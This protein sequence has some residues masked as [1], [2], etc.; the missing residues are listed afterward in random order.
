MGSCQGGVHKV[1]SGSDRNRTG[2]P[3]RSKPERMD[4]KASDMRGGYA[5]P[6]L[7]RTLSD[8]SRETIAQLALLEEELTSHEANINQLWSEVKDAALDRQ[9]E[10]VSVLAQLNGIVAEFECKKVDSLLLSHLESGQREAREKRRALTARCQKLFDDLET[11]WKEARA[12]V[13]EKVR[14]RRMPSEKTESIKKMADL[15]LGWADP[16]L[17]QQLRSEY[18]PTGGTPDTALSAGGHHPGR[19]EMP[20]SR[21]R[22]SK[23]EKAIEEGDEDEAARL[24]QLYAKTK[25]SEIKAAREAAAR[26]QMY[27]K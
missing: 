1:Q 19:P 2:N 9:K 16:S 17:A 12:I 14:M 24:S 5:M 4:Q 8:T 26:E 22:W 20:T 6:E 18:L 15:T 11:A 21:S 23:M 25:T 7:P 3:L 10:L 13:D 27:T